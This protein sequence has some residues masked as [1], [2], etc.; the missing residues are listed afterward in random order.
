MDYIIQAWQQQEHEAQD[1]P[2]VIVPVDSVEEGL[3]ELVEYLSIV[4]H[5]E[6]TKLNQRP[7]QCGVCRVW[8]PRSYF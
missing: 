4:I 7:T 8:D 3:G 6:H 1:T 5:V 2:D